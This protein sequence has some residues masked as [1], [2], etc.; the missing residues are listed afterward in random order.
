MTEHSESTESTEVADAE[1][2]PSAED[3]ARQEERARLRPIIEAVLFSSDRPIGATRLAEVCGAADGRLARSLVRE[4]Q[5]EYDQ[6]GRGFCIEE[7]AGGFQ[8]LS[9]PEFA[10]QVSK[11]QSRQRQETLS[12]AALETLAIVAYRQPIARAAIEDIRGVQSG[13]M[14]RTL[15]EKRLLKVAGRSDE[16]GRPLLYGTTRR[17]LVVFG[18]RSL[19]DLPKKKQFGQPPVATVKVPVDE[20]PQGEATA[21]GEGEQETAATAAAEAEDEQEQEQETTATAEPEPEPEG[22]HPPSPRLRRAGE[23]E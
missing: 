13:Q 22:E 16:V 5:K 9:R 8:L 21:E 10:P 12:K 18:L 20:Q 2:A 19:A 1:D 6:Q 23:Q 7:L 3:V 15:V 11:L 14:L 17:F 4:L